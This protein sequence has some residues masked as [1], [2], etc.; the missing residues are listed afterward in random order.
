MLRLCL[1]WLLLGSAAAADAG[2]APSWPATAERAA[3]HAVFPRPLSEYAEPAGAS[4]GGVIA[5]RARADWFNV[6][7][8]AIFLCAILHTFLAG[9]IGRKAHEAEEAHHRRIRAEGRTAAAK[10]HAGAVDDVSLK[11]TVLHFLA[12]VEAVFG[13]WVV[14]VGIVASIRFG[15]GEFVEYVNHDRSYVEPMFV[16][17]IMAIAASRPVVRF[18]EGVL[19]HL[20]AFGKGSPAAWWWSILTVGPVLGSFITEP[21]AMTIS[22]LLLARKFYPLRPSTRFAHATLGLLFVNISVG[23]TLTYFAAPPVLMIAEKWGFN[24]PFLFMFTH[25]GYKALIGIVLANLLYFMLFRKEFARLADCADGTEDGAIGPAA[26]Q[27]REDPVPPWVTAMHLLFLGWTVF[28]SHDPVLFIGGFLFFL[29]FVTATGHHQNS[30]QLRGPI[31]VGFFLA[32]LI[33]HGGLQGW[34]IEPIIRNLG[35]QPLQLGATILTAFN[36]NAAI[37]FLASQVPG[38]TDGLKYA[39]VAGAV[40]GGGLTVIANAP[41]PAGQSLLK[42][43]F[44]GEAVNPGKLLLGALAPTVIMYGLFT[45]LPHLGAKDPGVDNPLGAGEHLDEV[46]H[47]GELPG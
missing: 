30:I 21:G 42:R 25:F 23:G 1:A 33:I 38:L 35:E 15:F 2:K 29:A 24:E 28:V 6:A 40:I 26:W 18:A 32:A 20:A 12:E 39:V 19:S 27:E 44:E 13:L 43:F 4:M 36:D 7:A 9:W 14:A 10:G 17:V 47:A 16:V 11:A 41:N 37:T 8:S 22:A 45:L 46:H 34:W 3:Q 5:A 31:L